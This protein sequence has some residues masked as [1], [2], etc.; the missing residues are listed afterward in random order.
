MEY[1]QNVYEKI[2]GSGDT[3]DGTP[4]NNYH[5][6]RKVVCFGNV[7]LDRIVKLEE[8]ELLQR[9][10]LELG[11]KGELDLAKLN[12]IVGEAVNSSSNSY[13]SPGGSA[14][15]TVRILKKLG[16]EAQFFGAIGSDEC[17]KE[18]RN[19]CQERGIEA[20]LQCIENVPTG[21]CV[22]FMYNDTPTLYANIGASAHFCVEQ[23]QHTACHDTQSFLRPIERK[24]I[25]Y[26]EGFFVP[27]RQQVCEYILQD[28]VRERRHLAVNLSAPYIVRQHSSIMLQLA[29][30][31]L[32]VFGNRQ[33]FEEF[34]TTAGCKSV[35]QLARQLL[36]M[37]TAKIIVITNGADGVQLATN[38]E[39]E[40]EPP[41]QIRFE[42][43]RAQRPEQLV[44]AT[45][46]GDSFVAGFLHG[47]LE[48][49]SLG[50]CVRLASDVAAK[51]VSQVGC[52]LP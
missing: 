2:F 12:H 6:A 23:L 39:A 19:I 46:A 32:F 29:Q 42:D 41:G 38:F 31:A 51:V 37:G 5:T 27:Q 50:E 20:R 10:E 35:E 28:L 48:K 15:N 8:P 3:A 9:Y 47:W 49:R 17:A 24:Q 33:E 44:D 52:N 34:A 7:L 18:L 11:S 30:R 21:Q 45:G 40:L 36:E 26:L 14:L 22:C 16:T 1:L 4:A 43:Y 25:I 13:C